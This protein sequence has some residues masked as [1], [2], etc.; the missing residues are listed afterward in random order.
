MMILFTHLFISSFICQKLIVIH[1][2]FTCH[3]LVRYYLT[4]CLLMI[5]LSFP[6]HLLLIFLSSTYLPIIDLL[7][8][9]LSCPY[10]LLFIHFSLSYHL[11]I[12]DL[13]LTKIISLSSKAFAFATPCTILRPGIAQLMNPLRASRHWISVRCIRS[14]SS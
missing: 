3:V 6:W 10:Y 12:L 7:I 2:F 14:L 1:L 13:S 9:L 11:L 4:C 8:S 5:N